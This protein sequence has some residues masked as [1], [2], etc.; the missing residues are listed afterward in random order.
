M[1]QETFEAAITAVEQAAQ[2]AN[3]TLEEV[4]ATLKTLEAERED[5]RGRPLPLDEA[6]ATARAWIRETAEGW[7]TAHAGLFVTQFGQPPIVDEAWSLDQ[8]RLD[9]TESLSW[10]RNG[11]FDATALLGL[12]PEVLEQA[13]VNLLTTGYQAHHVVPSLPAADRPGRYADVVAEINRLTTLEEETIL[14]AR[15]AGIRMER[16]PEIQGVLI[17]RRQELRRRVESAEDQVNSTKQQLDRTYNVNSRKH[18]QT[19]WEEQEKAL[20]PLR[21]ELAALEAI[22]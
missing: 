17:S 18:Y 21:T 16:R 2:A 5:L 10:F 20:A 7:R 12:M 15:R 13:V 14:A 9:R 22:L 8:R 4:R 1:T 19:L 11:R 6:I 3:R